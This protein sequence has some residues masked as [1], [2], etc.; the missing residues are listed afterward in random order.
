VDSTCIVMG[1][2]SRGGLLSM[3]YAGAHAHQLAGVVSWSG[4]W[5]AE[6]CAQSEEINSGLFR[7]GAPFPREMLC[8]CAD[9]DP[10]CSLEH[11]RCNF[12]AFQRAGGRGAFVALT[13]SQEQGHVI[14]LH[15]ELWEDAV[16]AYLQ[17]IRGASSRALATAR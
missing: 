11:C 16:G 3:V 15:P 10:I 6:P 7:R 8:V 17:V 14:Q 2:T 4:G 9:R 13:P 1:G 12:A 5:V